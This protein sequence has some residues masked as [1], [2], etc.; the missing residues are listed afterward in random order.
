VVHASDYTTAYDAAHDDDDDDLRRFCGIYSGSMTKRSNNN[1]KLA[2]YD[3][4]D[5]TVRTTIVNRSLFD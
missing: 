2:K 5:R 3:K 1:T 4:C